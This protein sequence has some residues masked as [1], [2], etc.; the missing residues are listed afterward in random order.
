MLHRF[1]GCRSPRFATN[2]ITHVDDICS[3]FL[4]RLDRNREIAMTTA[5]LNIKT[6]YLI[7]HNRFLVV[8]RD[9]ITRGKLIF[10]GTCRRFCCTTY[11]FR[12]LR[13]E[14]NPSRWTYIVNVKESQNGRNIRFVNFRSCIEI[15]IPFFLQNLFPA[16]IFKP[17]VFHFIHRRHIF[18]LY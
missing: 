4:V 10:I 15:R 2:C 3:K 13:L 8:E 5:S 14:T 16:F 18:E 11:L 17:H 1:G 9:N 12:L 7:G 6:T